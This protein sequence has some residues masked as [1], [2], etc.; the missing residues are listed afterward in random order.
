LG[1]VPP[2]ASRWE[3]RVAGRAS[4]IADDLRQRRYVD[5]KTWLADDLLIKFDRMTMACSVEGR[6]P[7]LDADLVEYAMGLPA[8][9]LQVD[10]TNKWILREAFREELPRTIVGRRKQGFVL[11]LQRWTR[12]RLRDDFRE[13]L[14]ARAADGIDE[15]AA[16]ALF[17]RHTSG[18]EDHTRLLYTVYIYRRWFQRMGS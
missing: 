10:G 1:S 8:S 6:A 17:D 4:Q 15:R 2:P 7:Y 14:G 11:P 3:L 16:L 13:V 9:Q 12:E 18:G 5:L